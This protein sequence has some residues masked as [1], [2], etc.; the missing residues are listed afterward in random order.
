MEAAYRCL[1][2]QVG[3]PLRL[4]SVRRPRA[5]VHLENACDKMCGMSAEGL[6]KIFGQIVVAPLIIVDERA[7]TLLIIFLLETEQLCVAVGYNN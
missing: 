4:H 5:A 7:D 2:L 1:A 6:P 3:L